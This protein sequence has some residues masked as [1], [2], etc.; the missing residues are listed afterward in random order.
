MRGL[1]KIKDRG[2]TFWQFRWDTDYVP[3]YG[4][5]VKSVLNEPDEDT[6][7]GYPADE[8]YHLFIPR[9]LM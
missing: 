9:E 3:G 4:L 6:Y 1:I 5:S 8:S 7:P 2:E